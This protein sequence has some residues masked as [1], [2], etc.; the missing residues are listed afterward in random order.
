MLLLACTILGIASLHALGHHGTG[1]AESS[2]AGVQV[3]HVPEPEAIADAPCD[4][5]GCHW[6]ASTGGHPPRQSSLW[7]VC[8]A[9][10]TGSLVLIL[11]RS[12]VSAA[13]F[14][15]VPAGRSRSARLLPRPPP[16]Q[17]LGLKITAVSALRI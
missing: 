4:A 15:V 6:L 10:M 16:R 14:R 1:H 3:G 2:A 9:V 5:D 12:L 11:A 7:D 8:L 17:R 13:A